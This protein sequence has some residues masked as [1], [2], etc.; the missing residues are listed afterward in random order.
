MGKPR[1]MLSYNLGY[2]AGFIVAST[3]LQEWYIW[4]PVLFAMCLGAALIEDHRSMKQN[5]D[6]W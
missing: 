4:L 2:L 1:W 5:G 6:I 3:P